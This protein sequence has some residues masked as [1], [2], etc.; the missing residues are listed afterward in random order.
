MKR[1]LVILLLALLMPLVGQARYLISTPDSLRDN[2]ADYLVITHGS[3]T[4]ALDPLCRLRESLGLEVKLA[5]VG[6]IYSTFDSGPRPDRIKSF[7]RRVYDYWSPRPEFVL[8]VGDACRDSTQ[9]DLVPSKLFP[10]FSYYYFGGLTQHASDNWY[11][12]LAGRDSIP[13]LVLGRL[14][15]RTVAQADSVVSKIVRYET[16]PDTGLWTRTVLL[17]ATTDF[18]PYAV[19]IETTF[20]RPADESVYKVIESQGNSSFLRSR[21][22]AGFNQGAALTCAVTHG[23]QPPAWVGTTRTL[24]NYQDVDSLVNR[25]RLTIALGSG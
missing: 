20:F 6:L 11:V 14:P 12:Q 18:L 7:L 1:R 19:A 15:V 2:G 21:I 4:A 23:T 8:L 25:D 3:F 16:T 17:A 5:E 13:D 9:G 24:F 22:R 10:K